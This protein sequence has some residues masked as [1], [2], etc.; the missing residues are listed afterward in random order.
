MT[1]AAAANVNPHL[2]KRHG[3]W[4]SDAV[5]LYVVDS[6]RAGHTILVPPSSLH[7]TCPSFSYTV[8]DR[9]RPFHD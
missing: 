8:Y 2:V 9:M 7:L 5:Y 6:V 1:A 4:K 3:N